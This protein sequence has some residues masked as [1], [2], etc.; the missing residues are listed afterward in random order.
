[1]ENSFDIVI[2]GSG[3]GGLECG[4]TLSR[5]GYNVCILEQSPLLGGCLQSFRRNG[6][7][8]DTGMHYI[9]GMNEGQ[10]MRQYFKYFG[11][12]D[13]LNYVMLDDQF[14]RLTLG[15]SGQ[16]SL[17][18]GYS[19]FKESLIE[20][21]PHQK[22]GIERYCQK[23][24]EIGASISVDVHR[25]GHFSLGD[26]EPLSISASAFIDECVSDNTL[27]S[28]LAG[29][30]ALYGGVKERSNLYHHAMVNCSNIEGACHFVGGTQHIA[31]AFVSR[32]EAFGATI[33]N[34]S[35]V[36]SINLSSSGAK[37]VTLESGEKIF[38]RYFI[39][40]MHPATTFNL[41]EQTPLIKKAYKSRL[42]LLPNTYSIFSVYLLLK[43]NSFPY[44][45]CNNYYFR[46]Q[47]VWNATI[48]NQTLQPRL[49][50]MSSQ[51]SH[52]NNPYSDVVT[53]MAPVEYSLFERWKGSALMHRG[54][55]YEALKEQLSQNIIDFVALH[56]PDLVDSIDR[57]Y[58]SSPLTYE[59]YTSTPQGSAYGLLK[60]Y[61]SA[62]VSLLPAKTRIP[63]LYLTGQNLNV[64]GALGVTLTSSVTCAEFLG[65]EYLAKRIANA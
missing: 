10:I 5:E 2:I 55:D 47:D 20:R 49:V 36:V 6:R 26:I 65:A 62:L 42:N 13:D 33:R 38:G 50:L 12:L 29:T 21:F 48:N 45:N 23:L 28:V 30:N 53:L 4:L 52:A 35:R 59:D 19:A 32:I 11:V 3:L 43:P 1:M 40:N 56:R 7:V 24:Y 51:L 15:E 31:N 14:D 60:D 17:C 64:H 46:D 16:F 25:T 22:S 9:G 8:I 44:I 27:R 41:V 63:N 39:S 54:E 18:S 58:T 57:V 34:R 61:R 37:S